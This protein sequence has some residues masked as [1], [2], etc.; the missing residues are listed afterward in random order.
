L[1]AKKWIAREALASYSPYMSFGSDDSSARQPPAPPQTR[2]V[3]IAVGEA[4][5]RSA[6]AGAVLI[7]GTTAELHGQGLPVA[8]DVGA[9]VEQW[10]LLPEDARARR[11]AEVARRLAAAQQTGAASSKVRA[12]LAQ[13]RIVA[14]P[15]AAVVFGVLAALLLYKVMRDE[16]PSAPVAT[17]PDAETAVPETPEEAAG[18]EARLCDA[19]RKRVYAGATLGPFDT[20]GWVAELWVARASGGEITTDTELATLI[21]GGRILPA[22]DET[23]AAMKDGTVEV[24]PGS[25]P[26]QPAKSPAWR[27][28][29]IR[30]GG[31]YVSA[32]LDP[33]ERTRFL[34]ISDRIARAVSADMAGLYARC[35]HLRF[36]DLGAWFRG[37]SAAGATAAL[38]YAMGLY[39]EAPAVDR[40]ALAARGPSELDA[41]RAAAQSVDALSVAKVVGVQG[42]G[43]T[44]GAG[45]ALT[46][47]FPSGG[48]TRA[49]SASRG[50]ARRL[51]VG[52]GTD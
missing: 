42:G 24:V 4:L 41:L 51:G 45:G 52:I 33:A 1:L 15:F 14:V 43:I 5:A 30:F 34:S 23:L 11:V 16:R 17:S 50:L 40:S 19:A 27:G 32:Y 12:M 35:A 49:T 6:I 29:I 18:R 28:A 48:G 31:R 10:P 46:I 2:E 36:H 20:A 7:R 44:N 8:I 21:G 22:G 25:A 9:L 13:P 37:S 26:D 3:E 47:T 38:V 39:A